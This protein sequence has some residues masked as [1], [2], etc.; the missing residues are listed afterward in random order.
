MLVILLETLIE[1]GFNESDS[2]N[3]R[4]KLVKILNI[5]F[6]YHWKFN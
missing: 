2:E 4:P 5:E 3:F 1:I 6:F